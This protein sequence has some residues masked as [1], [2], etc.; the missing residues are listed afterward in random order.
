MW[1][2][3]Y[4]MLLSTKSHCEARLLPLHCGTTVDLEDERFKTV[5]TTDRDGLSPR[6]VGGKHEAS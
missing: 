4:G 2:T 6:R 3:E 5:I 1:L